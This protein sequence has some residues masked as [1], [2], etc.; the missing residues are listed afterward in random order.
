MGQD[1][2]NLNRNGK[3]LRQATE[4]CVLIS[5]YIAYLQYSR[6]S[7]VYCTFPGT[8]SEEGFKRNKGDN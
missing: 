6:Y 7:D 5:I 3:M 8:V 2:Y 1:V 4:E